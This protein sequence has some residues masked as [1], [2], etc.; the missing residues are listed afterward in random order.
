MFGFARRRRP[1]RAGVAA[2]KMG[3]T[4]HEATR[5]PITCAEIRVEELRNAEGSKVPCRSRAS[6][7]VGSRIG[8]WTSMVTPSILCRLVSTAG[9]GGGTSGLR[10]I[11]RR[12][13]WPAHARVM[14]A[15]S[16]SR[17]AISIGRRHLCSI[18][19]P[20]PHARKPAFAPS[21]ARPQIERWRALGA[22]YSRSCFQVRNAARSS[23][24]A[25][26]AS[27]SRS[28]VPVMRIVSRTCAR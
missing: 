7:R 11:C 5:T 16:A 28:S 6:A 13:I 18:G 22:A 24:R 21:P 26:G 1:A 27:D 25:C 17:S 3:R 8:A 2:R 10:A 12:T 19:C 4:P 15:R 14:P 23:S 20:K 9:L